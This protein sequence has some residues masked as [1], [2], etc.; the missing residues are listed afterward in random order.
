LGLSTSRT[1]RGKP[2]AT[3]SAPCLAGLG[4]AAEVP[5]PTHTLVQICARGLELD[6]HGHGK[7]CGP[8]SARLSA[9]EP[10][11]TPGDCPGGL[12]RG[13]ARAPPMEVICGR[14]FTGG[15]DGGFCHRVWRCSFDFPSGAPPVIAKSSTRHSCP[16]HI[17][18]RGDVMR[19]QLH[20]WRQCR[21]SP[22]PMALF[23]RAYGRSTGIIA[24][25]CTRPPSLGHIATR[26]DVM[27]CQLL[28][29]RLC[30]TSPPPIALFLHPSLLRSPFIAPSSTRRSSPGHI[31]TRGDVMRCQLHLWRQCRISPPPM[32]LFLRAYGRSA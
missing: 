8:A 5:E 14:R 1:T 6:S 22:P 9:L 20:L 23:L 10:P 32:A 28:L 21:I 13:A 26:T 25:S 17:A 29:W 3:P 7:P 30:R 15:D 18:T 12:P 11:R 24:P 4:P 2:D 31:A 16:G 27:R 19:C